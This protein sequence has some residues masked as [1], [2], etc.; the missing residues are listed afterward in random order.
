MVGL[1]LPQHE[2]YIP[3]A[4]EGFALGDVDLLVEFELDVICCLFRVRVSGE[5]QARGFEVEFH[6]F[7]GDVGDG[8][9]E[10]DDVLGLVG[11][12]GALGP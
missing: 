3:S 4:V 1:L 6:R 2:L 9:R 11:G 10:V 7:F 12:G 8:Y 5:R